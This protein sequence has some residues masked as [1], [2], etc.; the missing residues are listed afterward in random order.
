MPRNI[1][2]AGT[3]VSLEIPAGIG[4]QIAHSPRVA[5]ELVRISRE[6]EAIA[7]ATVP[8]GETGN[9]RESFRSEVSISPTGA[10][11]LIGYLA[12]YAHMV[13]NGTVRQAADPWLLNAALAVMVTQRA[14]NA[15]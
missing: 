6:I 2:P 12:F 4:A 11:L 9:L 14:R 1:R 7:Q 15:A 8:V 13:H 10:A 5:A 3:R